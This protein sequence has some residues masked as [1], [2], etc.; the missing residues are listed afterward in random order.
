MMSLEAEGREPSPTERR[1]RS[2]GFPIVPLPDAAKILRDAGKYGFEHSAQAFARYMGHSTTNSGSFRQRLSAFRDWQ[3]ITGRGDTVTFTDTGRTIALPPD[4]ASES[5]ALRTAFMNCAV[6]AS[7]Y[8]G[9]AKGQS[10]D[11]KG[12]GA[13][14]VHSLGVAASAMDKFTSSFVGSAVAAGLAREESNG[15]VVLVDPEADDHDDET[16]RELPITGAGDID[17]RPVVGG[18]L[19]TVIRQEWAIHGGS[20]LL[21]VRLDRPLPASVFEAIGA[22]VEK[23]EELAKQ[24]TEPSSERTG[25]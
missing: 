15:K 4:A 16:S 17:Q 21:E 14:A 12:L 9:M 20:V 13:R 10:L 11:P 8:E 2:K 7:L 3:L 1:G 6:F 24:L 18:R 23:A 19:Q 25:T 22:V 5:A